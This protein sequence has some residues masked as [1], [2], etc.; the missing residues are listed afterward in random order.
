MVESHEE[1]TGVTDEP[2]VIEITET[3]GTLFKPCDHDPVPGAQELLYA[4][5]EQREVSVI[6]VELPGGRVEQH[7][8]YAEDAP[9]EYRRVWMCGTC[10]RLRVEIADAPFPETPPPPTTY[11]PIREKGDDQ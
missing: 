4:Q 1:A 7:E 2:G 3:D 9:M 5:G 6:D 8:Y 10:W 11:Y